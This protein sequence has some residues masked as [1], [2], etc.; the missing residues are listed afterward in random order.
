MI[1]Y[2]LPC[3]QRAALS[4]AREKIGKISVIMRKNL[5]VQAPPFLFP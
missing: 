2:F 4:A 3:N 5:D 1:D